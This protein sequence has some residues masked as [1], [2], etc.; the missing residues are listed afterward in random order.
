MSWPGPRAVGF[1]PLYRELL[2]SWPRAVS[3]SLFYIPAQVRKHTAWGPRTSREGPQRRLAS[4]V[5]SWPLL[6]GAPFALEGLSSH[7]LHTLSLL[8]ALPDPQPHQGAYKTSGLSRGARAR[9]ALGR[10]WGLPGPPC[11]GC[12]R[13]VGSWEAPRNRTKA[14]SGTRGSWRA[15]VPRLC[16]RAGL[17]PSAGICL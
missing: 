12:A 6:M 10:G 3:P 4:R 5:L 15:L 2:F 13:G 7:L 11:L 1:H 9:L 17:R 14:P 16:L 8:R